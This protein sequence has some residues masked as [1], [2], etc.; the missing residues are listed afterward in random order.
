[1]KCCMSNDQFQVTVLL[2]SIC[3]LELDTRV[4]L[5]KKSSSSKYLIIWCLYVERDAIFSYKFLVLKFALT[6]PKWTILRQFS[7]KIP[8]E[9]PWTPSPTLPLSALRASVKLSA[10]GLGA[11][12]VFNR[13]PEEKNLD[14]PDIDCSG[15]IFNEIFLLQIASILIWKLKIIHSAIN[16][17]VSQYNEYYAKR[18][19]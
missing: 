12:A 19:W 10:S 9:T 7:K 1:M 3:D 5:K 17:D 6:A 2:C 8:G 15:I 14:T 13:A 18:S 4:N 16:F 11:P